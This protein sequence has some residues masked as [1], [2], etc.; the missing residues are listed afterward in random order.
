MVWKDSTEL[1]I[2]VASRKRKNLICNY[3]VARY[4]RPGNILG[5][6][7]QEVQKGEFQDA[8]CRNVS[9]MTEATIRSLIGNNKEDKVETP[10]NG[11]N[12]AQSQKKDSTGTLDLSRI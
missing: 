5:L 3:V 9:K 12:D 2:G 1:G 6:F 8:L 11:N 7:G 4:R 10:G